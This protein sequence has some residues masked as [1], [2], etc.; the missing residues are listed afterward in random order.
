MPFLIYIISRIFF[1][2]R[3]A[4]QILPIQM[5]LLKGYAHSDEEMSDDDPA[6]PVS[7]E[8]CKSLDLPT[9]LTVSYIYFLLSISI[10]LTKPLY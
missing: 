5:D 10:T 1:F 6:E 4:I 3:G 2:F 7:I 9:S 8:N